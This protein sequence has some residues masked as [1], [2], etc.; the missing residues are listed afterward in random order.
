MEDLFIDGA[1]IRRL[2]KNKGWSQ[3]D[4]ARIAWVDQGTISALE[5]N[6][7]AGLHLGTLVRLARTLGASTDAL[8]V[9][10]DGTSVEPTDP[11]LDV[12]IRLVRDLRDAERQ[13]VEMFLRFVIA[14]R[15]RLGLE[16]K[17]P[18]KPAEASAPAP[19]RAAP[20]PSRRKA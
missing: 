7:K 13:P 18:T 9:P 4:L 17:K 14:Q 1:A 8:L 6:A 16:A 20:R 19:T 12:L 15:R 2:R 10:S 11:Q 3:M 5:R